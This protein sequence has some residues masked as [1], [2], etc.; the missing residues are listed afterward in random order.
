MFPMSR[1]NGPIR[2]RRRA[3]QR[4]LSQLSARRVMCHVGGR[5]DGL[6][7]PSPPLR[8]HRVPLDGP[9]VDFHTHTHTQIRIEFERQLCDPL[10][11]VT[12]DRENNRFESI[13][14]KRQKREEKKN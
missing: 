10:Y 1:E 11:D 8:L 14:V 7:L 5:R 13:A 4:R 3:D 2:K 12:M 9:S 6:G